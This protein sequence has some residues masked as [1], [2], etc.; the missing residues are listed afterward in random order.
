MRRHNEGLNFPV[1]WIVGIASRHQQSNWKRH[2]SVSL[3]Q[4]T[5]SLVFASSAMVR[6]FLSPRGVM[7]AALFCTCNEIFV[8]K[9][10]TDSDR[11]AMIQ[12]HAAVCF[13]KADSCS[14]GQ[15][16]SCRCGTR[17]FITAST[18]S[19]HSMV[20]WVN[21]LQST[22]SDPSSLASFLVVFVHLLLGLYTWGSP[23]NNSVR[24]PYW[25]VF[26]RQRTCDR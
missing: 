18:K 11:L 5:E 24:L 3:Q 22:H 9:C 4:D 15:E 7:R 13:S 19:P 16:I 25:R 14:V 20:S 21:C 10:F 6:A 17:M 26:Q 12:L 23:N 2:V 1:S 8:A